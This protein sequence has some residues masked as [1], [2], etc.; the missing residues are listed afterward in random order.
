[1]VAERANEGRGP[2]TGAHTPIGETT[3]GC[4]AG[5][6]MREARGVV[7]STLQSEANYARAV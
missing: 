6:E 7:A 4:A 1:M 2:W 5:P 3:G